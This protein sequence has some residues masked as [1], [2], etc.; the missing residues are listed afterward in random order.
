M[1]IVPL[2]LGKGLCRLRNGIK[3]GLSSA[4]KSICSNDVIVQDL[5]HS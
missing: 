4:S 1:N 5:Y 3:L 2:G